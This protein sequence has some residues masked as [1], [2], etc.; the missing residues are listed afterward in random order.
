METHH[1]AC[2]GYVPTDV[3]FCSQLYL[4]LVEDPDW[5]KKPYEMSIMDPKVV[6][7]YHFKLVVERLSF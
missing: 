6:H 3:P 5:K 1:V 4:H 7:R 2:P